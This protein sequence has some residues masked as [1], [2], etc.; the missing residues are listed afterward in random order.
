MRPPSSTCSVCDSPRPTSPTR[1]SYGTRTLSYVTACVGDPF[2]PI[3]FSAGP[4]IKPG[5]SVGTRINDSARLPPDRSVRHSVTM[6][7]AMLALVHHILVPLM[8]HS[9]L[10]CLA[11]V[12]TPPERSL[13]APGSVKASAASLPDP[14][15]SGGRN[16]CFSSSEPN[17][18][19]GAQP[20]PLCAAM[21][22][23]VDP[24][25]RPI[26][27]SAIAALTASTP[28]PP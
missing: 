5:V 16:L 19:I 9:L 26:S 8:I 6:T 1:Y 17:R 23:P 24:Q 22:R 13:P 12:C 18:A 28:A 2:K 7:S 14:L 15:A 4:M 21:A 3:F 20:R 25:P 27:S 11:K 10:S